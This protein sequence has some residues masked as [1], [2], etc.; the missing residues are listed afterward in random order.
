MQEL[1]DKI[2][3]IT[4][5]AGSLGSSTA[6]RFAAQGATV[7]LVDI[8][9]ERLEEV[10]KQLPDGAESSVIE[11]NL[12]EQP[13]VDAMAETVVAKYG[14]I[15]IIA[16]IAGG[17]TMGPQVHETSDRDWDFMMD[18]NLRSI[19]HTS[20]AVIPVMLK[21]GGGRI[22][23]ISARAAR[24]GKAKMGPYCAS[25]AAVITL[26]ESLASE[27]KFDNINV[28][29]ILPGP[30]DTPRNREEM[31][32]ADHDKWVPPEALADVILF[33]CSDASRCVTGA[34]IP[35]FGQS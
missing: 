24:E 6:T 30:I 33:L 26:T 3:I 15:D 23:N 27:H 9:R 25:K 31:P 2:V 4:G 32:D 28:N 12:L 16:N 35:V 1:T 13:S 20:R 34:A 17:F 19:F 7:V 21:N 22:V 10:Q 11:T 14:T 18:L 8:D 5:A 29:C